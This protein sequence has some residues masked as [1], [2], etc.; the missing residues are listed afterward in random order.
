MGVLLVVFAYAIGYATFVEN[1][2]GAIAAKVAVYNARWFEFLLFLMVVNFA[3]MIFTKHLYLKSKWN[4]L[5]IHVALVIIILGAGVTR[6]YGFEGQM[7]IREGKSSN[8][9]KSSDTYLY[10]QLKEGDRVEAIEKKILLAPGMNDLLSLKH[11]WNDNPIEIDVLS[12]YPKAIR[13]FVK[14]ESGDVYLTMVVAGESG[15]VEF[16]LKDGESST[17]EG[18]G[19]SF[20]DTTRR[21]L[22]QI[23]QQDDNLLMRIPQSLKADS[24]AAEPESFIPVT[25]MTL[26]RAGESSFVIK[27]LI[28][29]HMETRT[30][31]AN[32][33]NGEPI[34]NVKVNNKEVSLVS[35]KEQVVMSGNT[36]VTLRIGTKMLELPFSLKLNEFDLDRYPGSN[37]PSSFASE[38]TVIDEANNIE[39]PYRIYMNHILNYGGYRFFQSSYDK[40]ERG[41]VLSVNHDY[42]GTLITYIGY[43]LL[44]ASLIISFLTKTRFSRITQQLKDVHAKRK[45]LTTS[46]VILTLMLLGGQSLYAQDRGSMEDHAAEFGRLFVQNNQGRIEPVNTMANKVLVKISKKASYNGMSA[47][48]VYLGMVT[49][50]EFWRHEPVIKVAE[51]DVQR[52]IGITG[53]QAAFQDFLDERGQYKIGKLVEQA[54]IKKPA[55]RS[56]L[57]KALINIDE[58]VNVI[59]MAINASTLKI[60]PI[61]NDPNNK[62][63]TPEENHQKKGHG[64]EEGDVFETYMQAL[65]AARSSN[66]FQDANAAL[67]RISMYQQQTGADIL[68]SK[69]KANL[70]IFYN[71]TNIFKSLFPVYLLIGSLL[72]AIFFLNIFKPTLEFKLI[73]KIFLGILVIAFAAQ[74]FGLGLRWYISGHAPWSNGYESMIYISWATMLA[75]FIFMKR[76]GITLG[77]TAM[78]AGITLLTAHMSWLNPELTNLVPV[79]KSYWLTIHVATITASYGFLGLGCLV[80][81]LN[82]IIMIF[83]NQK[84]Q[85]RVDLTLKELSLIIEMALS[86]GLVLLVIGN[87]LGGI[88]AN[89][90]WGR[91]WGWDPKETWTLVTVIIYSFT[92]HLTLIPSIRSTFTFNFMSFVSFGAVLMTYFGVNYYLSGLHSYAN[93]DPIA[94]PTFV[95]YT[96]VIAGI[97]SVLAAYNDFK[98]TKIANR[99]AEL[100]E[101]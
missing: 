33:Q 46:A 96:L 42:W 38:V 49:N 71:E 18:L 68:P 82:M 44:F 14:T 84:N 58:R 26:L 88:W 77:V 56:T 89:E 64:T 27:E 34:I 94:I 67:A 72:V 66:N 23:I 43:F 87:F 50:P 48:E 95:Y 93:G 73:G 98:F 21:D 74:T 76:S 24:V 35:G 13:T 57:D 52:L 81:L 28:K 79:L 59:Y 83:R 40:D 6:Y 69:T 25:P 99:K 85:L 3:G 45:T 100:A 78:L 19:I 4:I 11:S 62:W 32:A 39:M 12:F 30:V 63:A 41:T 53:D 51:S 17:V 101:K 37:S 31:A 2:Y 90:S 9:F 1:D 8:I 36:E 91:Y 10:A 70:E 47:D 5:L 16:N 20:G 80:A 7:H 22:V 54:Y 29:G 61:A 15:R 65:A 86:V 60:F 55:L 75:G 92:L 97:I